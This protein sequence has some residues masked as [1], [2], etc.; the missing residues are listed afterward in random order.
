M[1]KHGGGRIDKACT[2]EE[3]KNVKEIGGERDSLATEE[4]CSK[5]VSNALRFPSLSRVVVCFIVYS[6]P[7][8]RDD[9]G[10][11]VLM[12]NKLGCPRGHMTN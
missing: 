10:K 9:P 8:A 4:A 1:D 7:K 2:G 12:I 5:R 6:G 3:E 11:R